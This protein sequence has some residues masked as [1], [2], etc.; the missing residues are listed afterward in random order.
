MSGRPARRIVALVVLPQL[1]DP[2]EHGRRRAVEDEKFERTAEEIARQF[3]GGVLWRFEREP[4][5]GYWWDRGI[6]HEDELAVLE[7]DIP[8][9]AAS[10]DWLERY[11]REVLLPRFEQEAIYMKLVGPVEV[12]I[13]TVGTTK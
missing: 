5:H 13:V 3:G 2:D 4:P 1:Y 7:V 11:A 12:A 8:D 9:E 6:L 10:R